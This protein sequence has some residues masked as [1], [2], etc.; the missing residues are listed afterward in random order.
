MRRLTVVAL[1]LVAAASSSQCDDGTTTVIGPSSGVAPAAGRFANT[2][3]STQGDQ[4]GSSG[5]GESSPGTESSISRL[6]LI[7]VSDRNSDG[8]PNRGD[9]ITFTIATSL[10]WDQ[11]SLVCSQ[12]GEVVLTAKRTADAWTPLVLTS[13]TWQAGAADCKATLDRVIDGEATTLASATFTAGA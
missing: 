10:P 4:Q 6:A 11:V 2:G 3:G 9:S 8:R 1:L 13:P 12:D 5:G 7:V